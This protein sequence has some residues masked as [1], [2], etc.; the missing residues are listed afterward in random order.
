MPHQGQNTGPHKSLRIFDDFQG[1]YKELRKEGT[2][3]DF[4]E[5]NRTLDFKI[6]I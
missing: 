4:C 5:N 3:D 6:K 2:V 1:I